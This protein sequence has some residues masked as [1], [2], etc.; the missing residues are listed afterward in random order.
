M[1]TRMYT[2]GNP[3]DKDMVMRPGD[4]LGSEAALCHHRTNEPPR[5]AQ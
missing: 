5:M 1:Y 3:T 2:S 4:G